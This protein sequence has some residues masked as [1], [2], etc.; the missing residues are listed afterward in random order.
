[1]GSMLCFIYRSHRQRGAYLYLPAKDEFSRVP[2]GLMK[3][4]GRPEFVFDFELTPTRHLAAA[5]TAQVLNELQAQGYYLQ[6]PSQD[7]SHE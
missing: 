7:P 2:T 5:D 4:F 6:M 3:L 1:M